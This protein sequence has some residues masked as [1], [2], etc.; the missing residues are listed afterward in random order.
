VISGVSHDLRDES[1]E[2]KARWFQSLSL[3]ERMELLCAFTDLALSA[4]PALADVK[5]AQPTQGR[6]RIITA[7]QR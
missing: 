3:A 6:V 7:P 2:A 5:N 1:L 4:N